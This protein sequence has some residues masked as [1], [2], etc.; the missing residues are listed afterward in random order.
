M[1]CSAV[2]IGPALTFLALVAGCG[3]AQ[4]GGPAAA[5][6]ETQDLRLSEIQDLLRQLDS[7]ASLF[8]YYAVGDQ[9]R[10]P[11]RWVAVLGLMGRPDAAAAIDREWDSMTPAGRIYAAIVLQKLA[12]DAAARRWSQ[13]SEAHGWVTYVVGDVIS[14]KPIPE[15]A[16]L[17]HNEV[18]DPT[19]MASFER[20]LR[21][22]PKPPAAGS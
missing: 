16:R 8:E 9:N 13:L 21:A 10:M 5:S 20:R 18:A 11:A 15:V 4:G 3:P 22:A 2:F 7:H 12:P 6:P 1:R 17:M 14:R 19:K